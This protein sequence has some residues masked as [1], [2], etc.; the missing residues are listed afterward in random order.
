MKKKFAKKLL[1]KNRKDYDKLA[2]LYQEKRSQLTPDILYLKK[3]AGKG[4]KILDL[5]CGYG[6]LNEIFKDLDI[7]YVGTDL[8]VSQIKLARETYPDKKFKTSKILSQPFKDDT[9]DKVFCL[10][11]IHHIPSTDFKIKFLREIKRILKPDGKLVLTS[12]YVWY[13]PKIRQTMKQLNNKTM[14]KLDKNDIILPFKDNQGKIIANRYIHC[15]E[16]KE[17]KEL[18][19]KAGFNIELSK[20]LTRDRK[21]ENKNILIVAKNNN[22]C[23]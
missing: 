13:N 8:S 19:G 6:R 15:F 3:F 4:D 10:S 16:I 17:L 2:L 11:V 1:K 21:G 5:G 14:K 23:F 12:W 22:S 7:D 18:I 20:L 9:F